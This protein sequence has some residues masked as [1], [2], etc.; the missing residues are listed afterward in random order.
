MIT[1]RGLDE[2]KQWLEAAHA[3]RGDDAKQHLMQ[4]YHIGASFIASEEFQQR[5]LSLFN[6]RF[7]QTDLERTCHLLDVIASVEVHQ[8]KES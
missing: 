8:V 1:K 7:T 2:L 6:V 4:F 5:C 3:G